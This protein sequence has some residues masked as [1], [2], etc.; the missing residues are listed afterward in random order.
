MLQGVDQ[1]TDDVNQLDA[2]SQ[3]PD[4]IGLQLFGT[5]DEGR[6]GQGHVDN[7]VV[8]NPDC[9]QFDPSVKGSVR[10]AVATSTRP[11]STRT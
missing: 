10:Q 7:R 1:L 4:G 2:A 3:M 9:P 6:N 5:Q 11:L 8:A